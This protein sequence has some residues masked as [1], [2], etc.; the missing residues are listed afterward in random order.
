MSMKTLITQLSEKGRPVRHVPFARVCMETMAVTFISFIQIALI[1]GLRADLWARVSE[2]LFVAEIMMNLSLVIAAGVTATACAYPDRARLPGWPY[3]FILP[4]SLYA[5]V[6]AAAASATPDLAG[7]VFH[8]HG[9]HCLICIVI[10]A[11]IPALWMLF[12]LRRLMVVKP[13]QAAG[14]SLIMALAAGGLG[15]R[16]VD[17]E[18][19]SVGLLV[20][21]YLPMLILS[22]GALLL[23]RKI[24]R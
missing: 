5:V 11:I 15:I 17:A 13:M 1:Y 14:L 2:P 19:L 20:W 22:G 3:L 6:F 4:L 10:F 21:H 7:A 23:G 8:K 16:L 12:R 9:F 24:F 18:P